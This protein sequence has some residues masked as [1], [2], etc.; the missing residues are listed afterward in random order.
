MSRMDR[1]N[2]DSNINRRSNKNQDLYKNIYELGE[3]SNI[4]G[5][6]TIDKSNEVDISKVKN[7][8]K[9][10][11]E[12]QKQKAIKNI[13]KKEIEVPTYEVYEHDEERIYDIRDILD[14]AKVNNPTHDEYQSLDNINFEI[15]KELKEKHKKEFEKEEVQEVL[16]NISNTSKLNKLSDNELGLDMFSDLQ[17][18]DNTVIQDKTAVRALLNEA[19]Q[20]EKENTDTNVGLDKSFYTSSLNFGKDDFEQIKELKKNVKKNNRLV[21]ILVYITVLLIV[22]TIVYFVFNFIK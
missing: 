1:Y 16:D 5:I 8:L 18:Q 14:K 17:S 10:R 22:G 4:E 19:K 12:Y 13:E 11:E 15:L 20:I 6:A 3:Y 7:M 21:R 2:Q 9:N